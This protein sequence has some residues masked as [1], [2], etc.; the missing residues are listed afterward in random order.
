MPADAIELSVPTVPHGPTRPMLVPPS[1]HTPALSVRNAQLMGKQRPA[2]AR[3]AEGPLAGSLTAKQSPIVTF[4]SRTDRLVR[5]LDTGGE[6]GGKAEAEVEVAGE[7][8]PIAEQ[9][10]EPLKAP[11]V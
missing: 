10:A 11:L 6:G 7:G 2:S 9:A 5:N 1:S 8:G 4:Q 3:G